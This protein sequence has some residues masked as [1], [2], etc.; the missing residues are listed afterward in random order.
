M[1]QFPDFQISYF[2]QNVLMKSFSKV[3]ERYI[4]KLVSMN[5]KEFFLFVLLGFFF[6]FF[7]VRENLI[8]YLCLF[9][10]LSLKIFSGR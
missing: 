3:M 6:G 5:F 8:L 9:P 1:L 4:W 2:L 10:A 7:L